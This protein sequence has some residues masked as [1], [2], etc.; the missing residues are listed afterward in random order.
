MRTIVITLMLIWSLCGVAEHVA[1]QSRQFPYDAVISDD[2]VYA[3]SGP[4]KQYYPTSRFRK[5]DRVTVTRH[6][7][8]G[9]F[10]VEPPPGSFA[11]VR[12]EFLQRD[13]DRGVVVADGQVIAWVGTSFGD[14]HFVEQRRLQKGETVEIIA[15]KVLKDERGE[16]PYCKIK[17]P[18]GEF[19][20]VPGAKVVT[21]EKQM[22]QAQSRTRQAD[23]F[24][25]DTA[26]D[27][28]SRNS[29]V[30][31]VE[32][33]GLESAESGSAI[34]DT[35]S[36]PVLKDANKR[37]A[38]TPKNLEGDATLA[39]R[40]SRSRSNSESTSP[41]SPQELNAGS[42]SPRKRL[43]ELDAQLQSLMRG[44]SHDM[45][46]AEIEQGYLDLQ[47][48]DET[49]N[50]ATQRLAQLE[51]FK[52]AKS[53]QDELERIRDA[54][55]RR[56]Q[57]LAAAQRAGS[58]VF[59]QPKSVPEP[60]SPATTRPTTGNRSGVPIPNPQDNSP[61][62]NRATQP[63]IRNQPLP[64]PTSPNNRLPAPQNAP[65][66]PRF[67]G[68]GI[69]QRSTATGTPKHVLIHPN[70]KRLAFLEADGVDLDKHVGESM[71]IEGER[72]YRPDLKS[73]FLNVRSVQ[74]VKL[75]P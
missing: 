16:V 5:G 14:D 8:G 30:S 42:A 7:P 51:S 46:V 56:E 33:T 6:D 22:A 20:W 1:A 61:Q 3:R 29:N 4:G 53:A 72:T 48:Q 37:P 15:D 11:W 41:F 68:A 34:T 71:G 23:P 52:Q 18:R 59:A 70:G 38:P 24:A 54:T 55:T 60:F 36:I 19:R 57:E 73:D 74:P 13:G 50:S 12:Q 58:Q 25:G 49:A 27:N 40:A 17:P 62:P 21:S 67:S 2:E 10:M 65:G 39:S 66:K 35:K 43:A 75:K 64:Q 44:E 69:I 31:P 26:T 45:D 28:R 63:T 47:A 9:W 32:I